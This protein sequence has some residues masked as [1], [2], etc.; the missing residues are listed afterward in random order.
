V[1]RVFNDKGDWLKFYEKLFLPFED[2]FSLV[3]D[4]PLESSNHFTQNAVRIS[5]ISDGNVE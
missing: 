5:V 1:G 2:N 4:L 3:L